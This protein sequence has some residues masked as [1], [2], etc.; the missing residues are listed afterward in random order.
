VLID[1]SQ[2]A[3]PEFLK[4]FYKV[5]LLDTTQ[6]NTCI[7]SIPFNFNGDFPNFQL[8]FDQAS[9]LQIENHFYLQYSLVTK[10]VH[11][12]LKYLPYPYDKPEIEFRIRF[13]VYGEPS[14]DK[15]STKVYL[16]VLRS[17]RPAN[18]LEFSV[19][20]T[21]NKFIVVHLNDNFRFN[22]I[23]YA[24][25]VVRP[26]F[27]SQIV[28]RL[29]NTDLYMFQFEENLLRIIY[30]FSSLD[31]FKRDSYLVNALGF[32]NNNNQ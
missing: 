7:L 2:S 30:P 29:L 5:Y 11:V 19:P 23:I 9:N 10:M 24:F 25:D 21:P 12:Y 6:P 15:L 32:L 20:E 13:R 18:Q 16:Q 28:Y 4:S 14:A 27:D 31:D 17:Q 22:Q 26:H 1:A 3:N 8:E